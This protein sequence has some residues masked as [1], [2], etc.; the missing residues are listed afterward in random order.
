VFSKSTSALSA[1]LKAQVARLASVVKKK[2]YDEVTL[3][4]YSADTGLVS[5]DGSL[6]SAR[7]DGVANYLKSELRSMKVT[8]VKISATGEGAVAGKTSSSYSRVEVF[9]Q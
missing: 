2:G 1:G 6:S 7:A 5:L 9:V 3:F 4:G 8:G